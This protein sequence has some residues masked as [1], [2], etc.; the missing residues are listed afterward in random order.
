MWG[1]DSQFDMGQG[2]GGNSGM[3][4]NLLPKITQ[5]GVGTGPSPR[6]PMVRKAEGKPSFSHQMN[7]PKLPGAPGVSAPKKVGTAPSLFP[8]GSVKT[9]L[10]SIGAPAV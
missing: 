2:M 9:G 6:R 1:S 4:G 7:V 10:S 3:G 5:S 8:Q